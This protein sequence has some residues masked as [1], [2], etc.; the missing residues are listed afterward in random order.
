MSKHNC[1]SSTALTALTIL[2]S[3][4]NPTTS[5][6]IDTLAAKT[7]EGMLPSSSVEIQ[8]K[9]SSVDL[10]QLLEL[11]VQHD[12]EWQSNQLN[13]KGQQENY[14]QAKG[15]LLPQLQFT[16]QTAF[17]KDDG[18]NL[19]TLRQY[20]SHSQSLRLSQP[21]L[22]LDSWFAMK[23]AQAQYAQTDAEL[24]SAYQ[25]LIIKVATNYFDW[26][27]A[28]AQ[29]N[30]AEAQE[31]AY[32]KQR[33]QVQL[34]FKAGI[35][36]LTDV[37]EVQAAADL[38]HTRSITAHNQLIT[39]Q[40]NIQSSTEIAIKAIAPPTRTQLSQVIDQQSEAH[41]LQVA[42]AHN[43]N[44]QAAQ[45]ALEA[46]QQTKK[47]QASSFGPQVDLVG[48]Y[49]DSSNTV[50]SAQQTQRQTSQLSLQLSLPLWTSGQTTS[51]YRQA[52]YQTHAA[53]AHL[54]AVKRDV[55]IKVSN[56]LE[57]MKADQQI[58]EAQQQAKQS[59]KTAL[60]ATQAGYRAGIRTI[61]EVLQAES[62]HLESI[63]DYQTALYDS[64]LHALQFEQALGTLSAQTAMQFSGT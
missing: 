4:I 26:L 19:S 38:A 23:H 17:N 50:L 41:W 10:A 1:L 57:Q 45:K 30:F 61:V 64:L 54:T 7:T 15:Q 47:E 25:T 29:L 53:E 35:V 58:L 28:E 13:A 59:T 51:R 5:Y 42:Y 56:L 32:K 46:A 6:A 27:K 34:N 16:A 48:S 3:L 24:A 39:A 44:Y 20:N 22:R 49:T 52:N 21:L 36:G 63:K 9:S 62:A 40:K 43:P 55:Q 2:I 33:E 11:A 14:A 18:T 31:Q 37:Y 60:M 8:A 12:A